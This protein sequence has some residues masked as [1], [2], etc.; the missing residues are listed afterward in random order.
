M[1][2]QLVC[3]HQN[4]LANQHLILCGWQSTIVVSCW[5]DRSQNSESFVA[6]LQVRDTLRYT[7]F[8]GAFAGV[9]VAVDEGLA[10]FFGNK[11]C[12]ARNSKVLLVLVLLT[13]PT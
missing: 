12:A 5:Y 6:G 10:A 8:L 11:R 7:A 1:G 2:Q 3:F 13:L 9:Y 4:T